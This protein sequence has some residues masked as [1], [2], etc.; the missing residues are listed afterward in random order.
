MNSTTLSY[1]PEVD[2]LRALAV[3]SVIAY[4]TKIELL[5][6]VLLAGGYIGVDIFFV[7]SGYL[8]SRIIIQGY[9]SEKGFSF[10]GFYYKRARRLLPVLLV[11]LIASLIFGWIYLIPD[12]LEDFSKSVIASLMFVSNFYFFFSET[13]YGASSSLLKPLLHT[14]S[15]SIE[16]QFYLIFPLLS[17]L[18]LRLKAQYFWVLNLSIFIVSL[19]FAHV[20]AQNN[21]DL[22]FYLPLSRY[23]ELSA[24]ALIAYR[25]VFASERMLRTNGQALSFFG[26]LLV[27]LSF[28]FFDGDTSH[29]SM[30]TLFPVLGTCLIITFSSREN[31]ISN[32]L[33]AKP[34]VT[35]G[36]LSYS[37]YLWH[38]PVLAFFR[39]LSF[40]ELSNTDKMLSLL[41]VF[42]LSA[43]S[44]ICIEKPFRNR[45]VVSDKLFWSLAIFGS[46]LLLLVSMIILVNK[47]FE[48]RLNI[49]YT[50]ESR[51][52]EDS[53]T[54]DFMVSDKTNLDAKKN[55]ILLLGDSYTRH[56]QRL[57]VHINS[58][59][60]E[61]IALRYSG[62]GIDINDPKTEILIEKIASGYETSCAGVYSVFQ[63]KELLSRIRAVILV[64]HRPFSYR[65]NPFRFELLEVLIN[66]APQIDIFIIGNYFQTRRGEW[67]LHYMFVSKNDA[68]ICIDKAVYN[69]NTEE[70][71]RKEFGPLNFEYHFINIFELLGSQKQNLPYQV[72]GVPFMKDW[73]HLSRSFIDKIVIEELIEYKGG[74]PS[75]IT[76][77]SYLRPQD[78]AMRK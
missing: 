62:C 24:G 67:C 77:Q 65:A 64:S 21:P 43:I 53:L 56:W 28:L 76:L 11:V 73:N 49:V 9:Q 27:V 68:R 59:N 55:V 37:L 19:I 47:G 74:S 34:F 16:E 30:I 54:A 29:P 15:L 72:D 25:E 2:G 13:E 75:I 40:G 46:I 26:L 70:A 38:F 66:Y 69:K 45:K 39:Y 17:L 41:I 61:F 35:I 8:I 51:S 60:Y 1:R 14:W 7:I 3:L 18:T 31:F 63:D 52:L 50:P 78:N 6:N 12:H 57:G 20:N 10:S 23:W 44:Y 22:N 32:I 5:G 58:E 48:T 71:E 36:L 33:S 42:F 4:H